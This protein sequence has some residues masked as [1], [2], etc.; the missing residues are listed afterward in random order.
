MVLDPEINIQGLVINILV[1]KLHQDPQ[2]RLLVKLPNDLARKL[3]I[4][5][6]LLHKLLLDQLRTLLHNQPHPNRH[7]RH[8][9]QRKVHHK[10]IL[11]PKDLPK[12]HGQRN[13]LI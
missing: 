5:S 7:I 9:G 13:H 2:Q 1:Q 6:I 12:P 8:L 11:L 10:L 3:H 4:R